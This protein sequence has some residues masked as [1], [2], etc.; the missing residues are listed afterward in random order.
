MKASQQKKLERRAAEDF[1]SYRQRATDRTDE[2]GF[3]RRQSRETLLSFL[4]AT[5][6]TMENALTG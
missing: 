6:D 5:L 4:W 1:I 2:R 3:L